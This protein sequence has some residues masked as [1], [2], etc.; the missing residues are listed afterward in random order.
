MRAWFCRSMCSVKRNNSAA[1]LAR[2]TRARAPFGQKRRRGVL[3]QREIGSFG[4]TMPTHGLFLSV[5]DAAP[6]S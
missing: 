1:F 6:E 4:T 3:F 2:S 5:W